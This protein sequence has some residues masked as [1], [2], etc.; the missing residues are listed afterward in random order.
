MSHDS[1]AG[2][3]EGKDG[4]EDDQVDVWCFPERNIAQHW[5]ENKCR[6]NRGCDDKIQ[7]VVTWIYVRRNGNAD[8]VK[9]CVRLVVDGT[10]RVNRLKTL[11]NTLSADMCLLKVDP[12]GRTQILIKMDGHRTAYGEPKSV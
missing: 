6:Y 2:V 12:P 9:A 4:Y 11:R 5:T 7:T 1:R 10:A 3:K 8:C